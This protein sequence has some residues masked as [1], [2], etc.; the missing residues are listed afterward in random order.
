M[1]EVITFCSAFFLV[2]FG[3]P[4]LIKI[5][6]LKHLVDFPTGNRKVHKNSIPS[7]G[8]ISIFAATII[9]LVFWYPFNQIAP[10]NFRLLRY[11]LASL[12]F[13]FFI[14]IKDDI[15]GV[16]PLK[17][18]FAQLIVVCVMVIFGGLRITS[19]QGLFG[20]EE[21]NFEFSI[22]ISAFSFMV[23]INGFNLI[24]GVD[25]LAAGVCFI[26]S[27]FSGWWFH[28]NG[29]ILFEFLAWSTSGSILGFLIFN[30]NPARLFMGDSGALTIGL[31]C[32]VLVYGIIEKDATMFDVGPSEIP[33]PLVAISLLVYPLLDVLR[34]FVI[35]TIAGS[36]PLQ[37]GSDH[38]H[39]RLLARG[40][41]HRQT[42]AIVFSLTMA[43]TG[44]VL[45]FN[46][47]DIT[48]LFLSSFVFAIGYLG[49]FL[50]KKKKK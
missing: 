7:I 38:I 11:L 1:I 41:D 9:S 23:I 45:F 10:D 22:L 37:A 26:V 16:S 42:S 48:V 49:V 8:G 32:S 2:L 31:I 30:F 3:T 4:S 39:H 5:A 43:T 17:K 12:I 47:W 50:L 15:I 46:H 13:L 44:F 35:R 34:V 14:G 21:L 27:F 24:D 29:E 20:V 33:K 6:K 18:F 40:W 25:G 36:S 19:M 28:H